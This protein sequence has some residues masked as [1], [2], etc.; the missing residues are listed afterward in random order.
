MSKIRKFKAVVRSGIAGFL[1]EVKGE[2]NCGRLQ[3]EPELNERKPQGINPKILQLTV[4]P[5][6]DADPASFRPAGFTKN[7]SSEDQY[8]QVELFDPHNNSLMILEV[9]P[10]YSK[11]K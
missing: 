2:I 11:R 9:V 5:A 1:L 10:A 4:S 6:L 7:L 8:H 3:V